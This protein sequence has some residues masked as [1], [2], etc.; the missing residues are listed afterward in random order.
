MHAHC[1]LTKHAES[2][3]NVLSPHGLLKPL[4]NPCPHPLKGGTHLAAMFVMPPFA[5]LPKTRGDEWTGME[6]DF[7]EVLAKKIGFRA[8]YIF[9]STNQLVRKL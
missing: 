5:F 8:K 9:S 6:I 3:V 7:I 2:F 4:R 1:H